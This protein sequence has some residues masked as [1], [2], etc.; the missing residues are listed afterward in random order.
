MSFFE[1]WK[2][3]GANGLCARAQLLMPAAVK[4]CAS[5]YPG[6]IDYMKLI[7]LLFNYDITLLSRK[8]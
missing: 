8:K 2:S 4:N 7:C 3:E 1:G 5:C 6:W